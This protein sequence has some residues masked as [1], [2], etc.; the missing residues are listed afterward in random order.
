MTR[1]SEPHGGVLVDRFVA[2]E[3]E[4]DRLREVAAGLPA[5]ELDERERADLE[6]VA[7]GAAS[8]LAG[9]LGLDDYHSVLGQLRLA[10]GTPWPVPFTLAVPLGAAAS[11]LRAG[12]AS[13]LD[14]R[15]RLLGL[16]SIA[17]VFV[18]SAREEASAMY[19]SDDP[20]HPGVRYLLSRPSCLVGGSVRL[21]PRG[22]AEAPGPWEVRAAARRA[23]WSR[24][25]GLA[26]AEG[27]GCIEG[28]REPGG[29]LLATLPVALRKAPGRDALTQAL[30]LK[31]YG[32]SEVLLEY[33]RR[34]WC[35]VASRLDEE[36]LGFTPLFV[37]GRGSDAP[38][39]PATW[40]SV[41]GARSWR[42]RAAP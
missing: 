5:I 37:G 39:T 27:F 1:M 22:N 35:G 17:E 24:I 42:P 3:D 28:V 33:E 32:A 25:S 29:A 7:T 8:P 12:A 20:A 9:F 41:L 31:N 34:D 14:R 16:I 23:G 13:L 36:P 30:I 38:H 21:L 10:N 4:A 15:A 26:T 6:L 2:E 19:G 11:L 18:R 40:G